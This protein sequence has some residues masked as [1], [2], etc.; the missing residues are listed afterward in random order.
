MGQTRWSDGSVWRER[1]WTLHVR[2]PGLKKSEMRSLRLLQY[3][4][5]NEVKRFIRHCI[6]FFLKLESNIWTLSYNRY[7]LL[8]A[9]VC[10]IGHSWTV[11]VASKG[12]AHLIHLSGTVSVQTRTGKKRTLMTSYIWCSIPVKSKKIKHC[13]EVYSLE[14]SFSMLAHNVTKPLQS[15][16][17][18]TSSSS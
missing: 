9:A 13:F 4:K 17:R 1:L 11:I 12:D 15:G 5:K 14:L 10:N 16:S 3:I 6:L 2:L 7:G 8:A 18:V